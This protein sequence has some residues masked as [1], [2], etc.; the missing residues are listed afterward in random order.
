LDLLPGEKTGS[1]NGKKVDETG[2]I[3]VDGWNCGET[4][5]YV[6]ALV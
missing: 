2:Q 3:E 1:K 5:D 6:T 4:F